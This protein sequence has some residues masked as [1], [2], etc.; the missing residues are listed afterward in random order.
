MHPRVL[1]VGTVP[2]NKR[3]TSRAFEDYFCNWEK[4]NLAQIFS[5]TKKPCKG[6]CGTLFQITDQ[7]MLKRWMSKSV[8]TGVVFDYDELGSEWVNNDL[9]V[10]SSTIGHMYRIGS[11]RT[12]FTHCLRGLLWR[13]KYWC[14]EKLNQWLDDFQPE[15]VFLSFSD[16]FFIPQIALYVARRYDIPIVSSIGDDYFFNAQQ[17]LSPFYHLYKSNYRKLIKNVLNWPGSAIYISDKI[18]DKYNDCLLYTS[19]SPRDA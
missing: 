3:S 16:D 10:G 12:A 19:P 11:K 2:Y 1:I 15:C 7:R 9:E 6:H 13:K 17:T 8:E 18:R 4:E 14:T 5:N